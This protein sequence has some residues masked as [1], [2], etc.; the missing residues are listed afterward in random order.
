MLCTAMKQP[1]QINFFSFFF[2]ALGFELRASHLLA[3]ALTKSPF[4]KTE[5]TN[6]L[7]RAGFKK[8]TS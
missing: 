8:R 5:F 3:G 6:Y 2:A 7:P 4:S 1:G